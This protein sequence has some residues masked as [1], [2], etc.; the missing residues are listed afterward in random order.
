ML[1]L[2]KIVDFFFAQDY[3]SSLPYFVLI[4]G[5]AVTL[6]TGICGIMDCEN[7]E[8]AYE[9]LRWGL[10]LLIMTI[11]VTVISAFV[12]GMTVIS[13]VL[14]VAKVIALASFLFGA[15]LNRLECTVAVY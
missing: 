2:F 11:P 14:L 13:V 6:I 7:V 10:V 9:C 5:A 15:Y 4:A 12:S 8:R 1:Y 3:I